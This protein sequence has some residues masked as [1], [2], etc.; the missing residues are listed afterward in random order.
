[1]RSVTRASTSVRGS[2]RTD[3]QPLPMG[4]E[5]WRPSNRHSSRGAGRTASSP[6]RAGSSAGI[7][8]SAGPPGSAESD[9][10]TRRREEG[11][12]AARAGLRQ[13]A[14]AASRPARRIVSRPRDLSWGRLLS[15]APRIPARLCAGY[16]P[17]PGAPRHHPRPRKWRPYRGPFRDRVVV[18]SNKPV[19]RHGEMEKAKYCSPYFYLWG[20][21]PGRQG[22]RDHRTWSPR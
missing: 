8:R 16:P 19:T 6:R 14:A 20:S 4:Q 11:E 2:V 18:A 3:R 1:M 13:S 5:R 12:K 17:M 7:P 9:R 15:I 21:S 22:P 10:R